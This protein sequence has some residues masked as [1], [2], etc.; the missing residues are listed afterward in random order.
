MRSDETV[1]RGVA[2][3]PDDSP[4][5]LAAL[6]LS[7]LRRIQYEWGPDDGD[8]LESLF[9]RLKAIAGEEA[10]GIDHMPRGLFGPAFMQ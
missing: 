9:E 5:M 2:A 10:L 6:R 8:H 4:D 3:G 7:W 1:W